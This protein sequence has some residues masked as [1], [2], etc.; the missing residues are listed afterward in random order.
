[1]IALF[2][3]LQEDRAGFGRPGLAHDAS[4]AEGVTLDFGYGGLNVGQQIVHFKPLRM[5]QMGIQGR[6]QRGAFQHDSYA[7]MASPVNAAL[8]ALGL[9]EPA[10]QVQIV[11][12]QVRVVGADEQPRGETGH[13]PGHLSGDGIRIVGQGLTETLEPPLA[14]GCRSLRRIEGGG[15]VA[16]RLDVRLQ[17]FMVRLDLGQSAVDAAGQAA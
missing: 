4:A 2:Q 10:F 6:Q 9:S 11:S 3:G 1:M 13:R 15:Y 14:V 17:R 8:M 7:S 16:D 12:G 5:A